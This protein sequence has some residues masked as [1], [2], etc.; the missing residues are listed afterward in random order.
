MKKLLTVGDSDV[1]NCAGDE[2][3]NELRGCELTQRGT[4]VHSPSTLFGVN[5]KGQIARQL[6]QRLR[7]CN[8]KILNKKTNPLHG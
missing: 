6:V 8:N 4:D 5:N 3:I 2:D 1:W 7:Y